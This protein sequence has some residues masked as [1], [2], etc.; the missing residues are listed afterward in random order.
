VRTGQRSAS[1]RTQRRWRLKSAASVTA[2]SLP[3]MLGAFA[4]VSDA[5]SGAQNR[6]STSAGVA[7]SVSISIPPAGDERGDA[8]LN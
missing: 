8:S 2:K 3:D 6:A 5:A 7:S 1:T 4:A